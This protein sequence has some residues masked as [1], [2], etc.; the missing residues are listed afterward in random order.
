VLEDAMRTITVKVTQAHIDAL[1]PEAKKAGG[2]CCNCPLALAIRDAGIPGAMV[3]F[4]R[5]SAGLGDTY[6]LSRRAA[7]WRYDHD[8]NRPVR[9]ATF[10][11]QAPEPAKEGM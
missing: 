2:Y 11:L 4:S 5:W 3:M 1:S 9:P 10:R 8:N 6:P 7:K